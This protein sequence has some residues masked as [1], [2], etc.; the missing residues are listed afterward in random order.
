L[1]RTSLGSRYQIRERAHQTASPV[2]VLLPI[3]LG[4][5]NDFNL[6]AFPRRVDKPVLAEVDTDMGKLQ[7][8]GVEEDEIARH[9]VGSGDFFSES[10]QFLGGTRQG[11]AGHLLEDIANQ[12]AAV[13]AAFR[14][15]APESIVD[16]EQA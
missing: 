11:H 3:S 9:K 2:K 1:A 15:R 8:A 7:L 6:S 10:G 5:G 14:R 4:K 12:S 13:E 16:A